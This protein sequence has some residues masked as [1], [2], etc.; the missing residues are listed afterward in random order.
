MAASSS[1]S[2]SSSSCNYDVF[3]SF[4]GEDTRVSF[5]CHL[6]YNLNERTKIKTFIDDEELR[7]GDEISPALLNA[8]EGSKI[9]VVIF[10]KDYA[11]SK[12][13]LN[14]LVKILECKHTNGQIV[15][16]VFYSVSPCDVRHQTG[17]FGHGFDQLKQQLKEKPEM[18]QKWR[19]ALTET[20]HL[21]GHESTKFRHDAQ[22]VSKIVEDVLKKMEKIT[23]STDSSNGLVGLNSRIEQIKPFLCMDL[24]DTVQIVGIWGMGGIGKTTLATAIFNQFSR[25]FEGSCFMSDVRRNIERGDGLEDL[26]K[27]ILSRILREKLKVDGPNIPQFTKERVRRMKVLIVLDDVSKDGQLEGLIGGLDQYGPGSRIVITTRN[28]HV[29][30]TFPVEK[31]YRVNGL[32]FDEAF[33]HFC[34]FAFKEKHCPEDFKRDSRRVVKYADGNPLVLKVLGS[35]LKRKS[36]W[37][38]VLDD[39]NRICESDI[40]NIYDIL[41]ISFNELTP[42]VKSVFLDIA[43]FFEG[44]DK[45][46]VTRILDDSGSH[47]LDVLVDKSLITVSYNGLQMHDL[48]QEMG[49]QI[50]RQESEKEPGKRSR[51]WDPKE[52]RRVLKHNK[53]TDAI[54]GIFLNLSKIKGI[55]LDPGAFTNMSNLR[56]LKFYVPKF[57]EI[58]KL[59]SMSIEEQLSYSKVQLPKGLD[60]LPKILRYLHWDTYPLRTLPSNFKAKNLV[61]LNLRFS[62]VE[63]LW[64]GEKACVPSSIQN[65]K[66]LSALSFEGCK[67]LRSFP[68]NLH[69]VCPV[70]INFSY[71]VNLIE[72]PQISGK[73]TRLYLDQSAIEEVPS[74]IEC[75]TDLKV[76]YLRYCKRLKTISTRFCKLRS[77]VDLFL[78]GCLNLERFPEI[79]EKMEHLKRI[80]L[81]QTAITELPSSFENLPGLEVLFV[82][83]CSKLDKLPDNI[84]NL[85]SLRYIC[86]VGSTISQLPSSVA[87]SNVLRSLDFS[88]CKGLVSLPRSLLLGLSSL[89]LLK[90]SDCAVM[91]IPQ[92]IACL[93]SLTGLHLSGNNF[94]SLPASI[95]QL[96]RLRSLHLEGCKMLQSLPELPLCLKSLELRDCKMLQSLPALPLCLESLNLTGCNMLRSLPELPLCLKYLH[97]E[98]CNMLRSLPELSLCLQSLNARN[99]KRLQSLPEIPSCLQEL[100]ASV[101]EKLSKPS[102]DLIQWAPGRLESQ[103]IYFG[104]TNCLKLNGKAN[105]KILAD[106][107]LRIRHMA[108]ASLR[109]GYEKAINEVSNSLSCLLCPSLLYLKSWFSSYNFHFLNVISQKLSELR[110]SLIVLPGSE[111]PDWFSN[112]SSGSS[113]CIQLPPHSFC[114]N[115]IGFAFCAVPDLK[116][117]DSDCFRFFYVKC[118]FD[119]E[120][121]TL[122]ETKHVDLGYNSLFIEELIDSDHVILGFKPCLNVGFPDGYHR[123]TATL[124]FFAERN[125]KGQKIKRCGVCPVYANPSET[126]DN[127]FTINF[128]TEVW[129]L[130]DLPS[131]SGTSDVEELEPSPKRI[132]RANQINTP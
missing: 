75:L 44:E 97:L 54:E 22:L 48:L 7:R 86:A 33:E 25:E 104:F 122:S 30:E 26:Q 28:K 124:K 70:T 76:L 56:L 42:N 96:S 8:I 109:L 59:L 119:L 91:E 2:S 114:R 10:S 60:C 88:G 90:I 38:N 55:N 78:N 43:C 101:L 68:S 106:S 13:C 1:S 40:H 6:H 21:A 16:P 79:L 51:L 107:L 131:A 80:Y 126:K 129:K 65:F 14:E 84:G 9:S 123:A 63:Q 130:D 73:I 94:E 27:Q 71:C 72:F 57:Y 50:V 81:G 11:S 89:G 34:N 83:D 116:Q 35:S 102:P 110:G 52:I 62:K 32:K 58:E 92:E 128:A 19:D 95:K 49:R 31:I 5:T 67:S 87:D 17:S 46:I 132:C 113:I 120:I 100:D 74:S 111:I 93:S 117:V 103:P 29:L 4:R 64:E 41:K 85:E 3:L 37:G 108:I 39:L 24:S 69:F 98:D 127:T 77:L 66:Y 18:V 23:V 45:D 118:Q 53:G 115:L 82:E 12:W 47:R 105:N 36:H 112:Q 61:E 99:C 20:S 125:Q 121:E 15:V